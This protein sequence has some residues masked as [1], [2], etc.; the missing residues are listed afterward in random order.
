MIGVLFP[1]LLPFLGELI[2]INFSV[3]S[4]PFKIMQYLYF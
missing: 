1:D 4:I 2:V 3:K